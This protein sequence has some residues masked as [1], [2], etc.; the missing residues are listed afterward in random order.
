MNYLP[1]ISFLSAKTRAAL[2]QD[3][4]K[5]CPA[6]EDSGSPPYSFIRLIIS[7]LSFIFGEETQIKL[8]K[9]LKKHFACLI[10]LLEI[11]LTFSD[12]VIFR[13]I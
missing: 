13:K 6:I 2:T 1:D 12:F 5:L 10:T 8:Q 7:V 11:L 9:Y 3:T 4:L